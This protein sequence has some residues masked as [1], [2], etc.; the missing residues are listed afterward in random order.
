MVL[1]VGI[2]GSAVHKNV[3]NERNRREHPQ[4]GRE[5]ADGTVIHGVPVHGKQA[6]AQPDDDGR[7]EQ[8]QIFLGLK[9]IHT[10]NSS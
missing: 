9:K 8:Q 6:G 5:A 7:Y 2:T 4:I 1:V 10:G 3:E